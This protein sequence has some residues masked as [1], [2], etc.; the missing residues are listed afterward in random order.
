[1]KYN[2]LCLFV[3]VVIL[4]GCAGNNTAK[5]A[6][7]LIPSGTFTGTFTSLHLHS[8]TG[9]IDTATANI[10]LTM[11]QSGFAVTG[12]TATVHAGSYGTY[13]AGSNKLVQF[14][15]KTFPATGTP[16]KVHLSGIYLYQY[17]G[18]TFQFAYVSQFD[19]LKYLYNFKKQ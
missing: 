15:D 4:S 7:T 5:P 9:V 14:I 2:L 6:T 19:T 18:T 8:R 16:T 3:S 1:M 11:S 10:Q 13:T 17:D 12:D